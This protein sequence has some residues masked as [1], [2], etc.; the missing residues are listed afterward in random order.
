MWL[1]FRLILDG[2]KHRIKLN[3]WKVLI[4]GNKIYERKNVGDAKM[5]KWG[6]L[7]MIIINNKK[8]IRENR[9]VAWN[10]RNEWLKNY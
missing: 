3:E 9:K 6:L 4:E 10:N 2:H 1:F 5:N 8:V 7:E